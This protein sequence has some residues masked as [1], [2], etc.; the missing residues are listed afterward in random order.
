[1][2]LT[3]ARIRNFRSIQ[4]TGKFAIGDLCCLVG[5][6]EAGKTAT[7]S[8]LHALLPHGEPRVFDVMADYPRRFAARYKER[9]PNGDAVVV[10]TWWTMCD[11]AFGMLAEAFGEDALTSREFTLTKSYNQEGYTSNFGIREGQAVKNIVAARIPDKRQAKLLAN[12][13]RV[14]DVIATLGPIEEPSEAQQDLLRYFMEFRNQSI[15]CYAIDQ[16]FGLLPTFFYASHYDRMSGQIS[17]DQVAKDKAEGKTDPSDEIFLDFLR[18]AGTSLEE[19][20]TMPR[21]EELNAKIEAASEEIA[22]QIFKYWS[23]NDN[24]EVDIKLGE[25]RP[26]DPEPYNAG[27]VARAR[28]S[29]RM[30]RGSVSFSERSAGFV[31]F[32]SFLVRFMMM[33]RSTDNVVILLDEPGL[34][35][36]G[37]AQMDLL[38]Y[39]EEEL[40]PVHQVIYTTHSPF[41]VPPR[42]LSDCRVVEDVT[43]YDHRGRAEA[44]GTKISDD[45]MN[46]DRDTLLPLQGALAYEVTRT[47]YDGENPLLVNAP[48]DILY[49]QALSHELELR[50][51]EGL[52]PAWTLCPSGG[53]DALRPFATLFGGAGGD[54]AMLSSYGP[55]DAEKLE[56]LRRGEI[57]AAERLYSVAEFFDRGEADIEDL[58]EPEL[59][60][61]ILNRAY[62]LPRERALTMEALDRA[63]DTA[64]QVRKAAAYFA[65]LDDPKIRFSPYRP[66]A[67][68][69]R[70]GDVLSRD[71]TAISVTL[72]R[73]EAIFTTYNAMLGG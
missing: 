38:R 56:R 15:Q 54:V 14:A 68:L 10:E 52:D 16:V 63:A 58:L 65:A 43:I 33:R 22:D 50:G 6:N 32:F 37:R 60:V 47:L 8:A 25:G 4:D 24:L 41:M 9:H 42:R 71:S 61:E 53:L 67:W 55:G 27:T 66:A 70:N 69:I 48:S 44:E 72:D 17:I 26:S 28:V 11:E 59:F 13:T 31:W 23:Q 49:L 35:L 57:F 40:L 7:L 62:D 5:K 46:A 18:I 1:M 64:R 34:T 36:H 12:A 2:K 51:R 39:I 21:F 20:R 30:Q 29:N 45:L 3:H 73:A 19:L